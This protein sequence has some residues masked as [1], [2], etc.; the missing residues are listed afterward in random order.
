MS[1]VGIGSG[2]FG[3]MVAV[4]WLQ[5]VAGTPMFLIIFV[6]LFAMT[7][8]LSGQIDDEDVGDVGY[9]MML[10]SGFSAIV[11]LIGLSCIYTGLMLEGMFPD[12]LPQNLLASGGFFL[13]GLFIYRFPKMLDRIGK[14]RDGRRPHT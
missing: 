8:R 2:P 14:W 1:G 9:V 7:K 11:Y 4:E 5:I 13:I 10:V 12:R 3:E 6:L